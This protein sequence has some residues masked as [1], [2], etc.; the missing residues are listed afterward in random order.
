MKL[1][2]KQTKEL[3]ECG[4]TPKPSGGWLDL[5]WDDFSV[6]NWKQVC[7]SLGVNYNVEKVTI[8]LV[9]VQ[10]G[11][12]EQVED[13]ADRDDRLYHEEQDHIAMGIAKENTNESK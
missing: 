3:V 5:Y 7:D 6:S 2:K 12:I 8:A 1:T 11:D 10:S 4:Y 13:P 9:G